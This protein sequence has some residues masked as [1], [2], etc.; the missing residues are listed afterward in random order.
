MKFICL[1]IIAVLACLPGCV[2]VGG[3]AASAV[4]TPVAMAQQYYQMGQQMMNT[5]NDY[6]S[7]ANSFQKALE[8]DSQYTD[9]R[10][11]LIM[12][13]AKLDQPEKALDFLSHLGGVTAGSMGVDGSNV[14][15]YPLSSEITDSEFARITVSEYEKEIQENPYNPR[16]YYNL[17]NH[18]CQMG[19]NRKAMPYLCSVLR[20]TKPDSELYQNA[21]RLLRMMG[22]I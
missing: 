19:Q 17:G 3:A 15:D 5:N 21:K 20:L 10:N 18:Y 11:G 22:A 1:L 7:A 9:A 6:Q 4:L 12:A 8:L 16:P 2:G 13:Y 14:V